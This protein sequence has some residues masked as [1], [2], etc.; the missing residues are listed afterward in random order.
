MGS[1]DVVQR[2]NLQKGGC[3]CRVVLCVG[4]ARC[5]ET[6]TSLNGSPYLKV[7][8]QGENS[9]SRFITRT[10]SIGA[11]FVVPL[12]TPYLWEI[13]LS[14]RPSGL[15]LLRLANSNT[16]PSPAQPLKHYQIGTGVGGKCQP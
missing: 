3:Y 10:W 4:K 13:Q 6:S 1:L 5:F 11:S 9:E 8:A 16:L 12:L 2:Y 14:A 15:W 7:V